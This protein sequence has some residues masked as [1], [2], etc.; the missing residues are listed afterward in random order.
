MLSQILLCMVLHSQALQ[1]L[2]YENKLHF[3]VIEQF[4]PLFLKYALNLSQRKFGTD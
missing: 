3:A 4:F 2:C 1:A